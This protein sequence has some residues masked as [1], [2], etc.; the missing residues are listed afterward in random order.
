MRWAS[1]SQQTCAARGGGLLA[2][3]AAV[4]LCAANPI[5]YRVLQIGHP[6]E[7]LGA[8][9]CVAAVLLA[10]ARS[11]ELGRA[12]RSASR[13]RTRNGRCSRSARSLVALPAAR[14]R[15]LIVAGVVAGALLAPIMLCFG[16]ARV[17]NDTG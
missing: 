5:T 16:D 15:A 7:L 13:S 11:R 2:A 17:R 14:W 4:A 6:E 3:T 9:L 12:W 8:A 1:G 10:P